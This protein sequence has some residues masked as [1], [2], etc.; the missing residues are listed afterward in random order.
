MKVYT[1]W[2]LSA[3]APEDQAER[4]RL[5]ERSWSKQGWKPKILSILNAKKSRHFAPDGNL[6]LFALDAVGGGWL[7]DMLVINSAFKPLRPT[8]DVIVAAEALYWFKP[9]AL[10]RFVA[11]QEIDCEHFSSTT[12]SRWPKAARCV[13][14]SSVADVLESELCH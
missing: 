11:G 5:W 2:D 1:Y 6:A 8:Q 9:R 4:L 13:L 3:A 12:I 14:F 7:S 10:R